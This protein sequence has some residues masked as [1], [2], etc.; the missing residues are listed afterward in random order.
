MTWVQ[1]WLIGAF[2][3][4]AGEGEDD[5]RGTITCF[6]PGVPESAQ[7][8]F[9]CSPLVKNIGPGEDVEGYTETIVQ[10]ERPN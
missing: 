1:F 10:I 4:D 9:G 2:I 7:V 8:C 3:Y 5:K 6:A